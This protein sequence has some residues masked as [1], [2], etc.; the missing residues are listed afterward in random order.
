MNASQVEAKLFKT[1]RL[2]KKLSPIDLA[3]KAC[4]NTEDEKIAREVIRSLVDRGI[5]GV[6]LDW[7]VYE[8][9]KAS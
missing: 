6:D 4:R 8:V 7:K 3:R 9:Q 2:F 1:L 5:L